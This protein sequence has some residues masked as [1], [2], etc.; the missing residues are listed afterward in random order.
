MKISPV[1][2]SLDKVPEALRTYYEKQADGKFHM[3]FDGA[4]AGFAKQADLDAANAKIVE[5]RDNN[6]ALLKEIEPLRAVKKTLGDLDPAAAVAA[7]GK[8]KELE[9]KGVTKPDDLQK[10]ITD[11]V[12]AATKPLKDQ[13]TSLTTENATA[14]QAAANAIRRSQI[15]EAF[16][17]LGGVPEALDFVVGRA[18]GTFEVVDGKLKAAQNKF[19]SVRPGE[20]LGIEEWLGTQMKEAPFAF[21]PSGGSGAE[22]GPKGK[23]THPA[24]QEVL[25]DPSPQQLGARAKDIAEKKVRVEYS[26]PKPA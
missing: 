21:K 12:E 24:G 5:F 25:R 10:A 3:S 15:G 16:T 22:G 2:D 26:D 23:A 8:V 13:V 18:E 19:S 6:V 9:T 7:V 11:A 4:P 1:V 14:K 17:K 20:A